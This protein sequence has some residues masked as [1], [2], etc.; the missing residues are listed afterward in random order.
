[1]QIWICQSLCPASETLAR[2]WGAAGPMP[3]AGRLQVHHSADWPYPRRS[4]S[5]AKTCPAPKKPECLCPAALKPRSETATR[6]SNA[7]PVL[8]QRLRS[9]FSDVFWFARITSM[10]RAKPKGD[11]CDA[12]WLSQIMGLRLKKIRHLV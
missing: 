9:C 7:G 2:H 1:M 3:R 8:G 4:G 10:W 5:V 12:F 6:W 11:I